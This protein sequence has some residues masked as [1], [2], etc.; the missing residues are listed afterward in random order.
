MVPSNFVFLDAFPLT[1][2]NKVDRKALPAPIVVIQDGETLRTTTPQNQIEQTLIEI[3]QKVL[4]VPKVGTKDNFFDLGGNSLVA[5]TLIG[6]I[7]SAFNVNLPLISLFRSPT[8]PEIA[9]EIK[10]FQIE[11]GP[12]NDLLELIPRQ[13]HLATLGQGI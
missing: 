11:P 2:N 4:Q 9:K 8:V 10:K 7:R 3:W 6:E 5:V 1:P 12:S 13:V